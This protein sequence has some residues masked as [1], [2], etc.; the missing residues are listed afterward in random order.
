MFKLIKNGIGKENPVF[1]QALGMCPLLA[2]TTNAFNGIG[3]GVSTMAV[4]ICSNLFISLLRGFVP[5]AA[6]IPAYVVVIA[7]FVT[8]VELALRAYVPAL[9]ESLGLFIPLIVTNCLILARA[10]A[11]ASKNKALPSIVDAIGMGLGFT[12]VL[13]ALGAIRELLGSGTFLSETPFEMVL[14]EVFPRTILMI[15]PP[16]AFIVLGL[17]MATLNVMGNR[18]KSKQTGGA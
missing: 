7:A 2:V 4:L 3:M 17:M 14:P 15:L 12:I 16:G 13:A 1:A 11:F 8:I 5:S 18:K 9:S 10:E 6:R